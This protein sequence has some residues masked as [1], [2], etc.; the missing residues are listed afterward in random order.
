M[1]RALAEAGVRFGR[2]GLT[3]DERTVNAWPGAVVRDGAGR[4]VQV[5]SLEIAPAG[6]GVVRVVVDPRKLAH[7]GDL[8]DA[9]GVDTRFR[10]ARRAD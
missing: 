5:V 4:V 1:A 9:W 2:L 6:V 10:T 3:V 8:A 7:L